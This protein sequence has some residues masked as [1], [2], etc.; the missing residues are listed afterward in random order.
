MKRFVLF[1]LLLCTTLIAEEKPVTV[2]VLLTKLADKA[3]IEVKGRH[4]LYNP[5][6]EAFLSSSNKKKKAPITAHDKGLYWDEILSDI[7]ALRIVPD[8]KNCSILVNGIQYKGWIEI[9][10]IG[11]TIN[12]INEVDVEN[13]LKAK[14][15]SQV[16]QKLSKET[17]DAIM[18]TERTHLY[19]II[20][21][22]A[23]ATW[24]L[25]AEKEG[26]LG[27][28]QSRSVN[29]AIERTRDII[30]H[31]RKKS[32]AASWGLDHGGRSVSFPA[33]FR[34]E[35]AAPP[36][37]DNLPSL[38]ER[39]KS[40]WKTTIPLQALEQ[41]AGQETLTNIEP[42]RAEKSHKVYALRFIG[43]EGIKDIDI[44]ALQTSL[45]SHEIPSNDFTVTIKGKKAHFIGYGKGLGTGL[46]IASAEILAHR[47]A[48]VE[49][50]LLTH[51]PEAKLI[52]MRQETGKRPSNSIV[53]Q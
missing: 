22:G 5:K 39:A 21:K 30:L 36:G 41:I 49:K 2:R 34:I 25:E 28:A 24:Q 43:P 38:H 50:I 46:C 48:S 4:L 1:F 52:N 29:D 16:T 18:I 51:F 14:L 47:N 12:I 37:V 19:H 6:T 11:G 10:N 44:Q 40:K 13:Y 15:S 42:F 27:I 20:E 45:G 17:L 32:F 23:Y 8:E 26:Y 53:W 9:Y 35:S 7:Y 33:I 31:Y 3:H